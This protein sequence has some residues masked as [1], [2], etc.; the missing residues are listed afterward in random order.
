MVG[1]ETMTGP[2]VTTETEMVTDQGI[3]PS[4]ETVSQDQEKDPN[5]ETDMGTEGVMVETTREMARISK[6]Q[7][8]EVP[9]GTTEMMTYTVVIVE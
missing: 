4:Q 6:G 2:E 9:E 8:T 3:G 5:L 7:K 1:P